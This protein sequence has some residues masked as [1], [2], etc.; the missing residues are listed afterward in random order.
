MKKRIKDKEINRQSESKRRG[1][2][3]KK[4]IYF[5]LGRR[6]YTQKI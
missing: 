5:P 2:K 4:I 1:E 3:H 6:Q